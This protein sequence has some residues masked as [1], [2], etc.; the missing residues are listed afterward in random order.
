MYHDGKNCAVSSLH[1]DNFLAKVPRLCP[2]LASGN[3]TSPYCRAVMSNLS[4]MH[5]PEKIWHYGDEINFY[6]PLAISNQAS[7]LQR[8]LKPRMIFPEPVFYLLHDA[9]KLGMT[10]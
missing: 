7:F 3:T 10:F 8:F 1:R 4:K 5:R 2:V 6:F 9:L